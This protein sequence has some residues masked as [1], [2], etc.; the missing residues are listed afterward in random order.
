MVQVGRKR[1]VWRDIDEGEGGRDEKESREERENYIHICH[2]LAYFPNVH[3]MV[4]WEE[5][6]GSRNSIQ[7][8]HDCQEL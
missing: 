6:S 1:E 4:G 2:L 8:F 7:V 5:H 3:N